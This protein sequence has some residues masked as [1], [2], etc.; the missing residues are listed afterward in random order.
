MPEEQPD[1]RA[2]ADLPELITVADVSDYLKLTS[3]AVIGIIK[4]GDL[5]AL[6][7]PGMRGYRIPRQAFLDY[8]E[9]GYAAVKD[10]QAAEPESEP[11]PAPAKKR[12]LRAKK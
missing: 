8:L 2:T 10:E 9:A 5:P 3:Q 4:R 7:P 11:E 1:P 6:K 12:A